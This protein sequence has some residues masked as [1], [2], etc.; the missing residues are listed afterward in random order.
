MEKKYQKQ[1]TVVGIL[2]FASCA[3]L[4][5]D[6]VRS[7]PTAPP[8]FWPLIPMIIAIIWYIFIEFRRAQ[9]G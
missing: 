1:E 5:I 3:I 6:T 2:F 7:I 9:D 8:A 4:I